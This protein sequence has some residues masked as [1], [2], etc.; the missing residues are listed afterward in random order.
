[1]E[2]D[3]MR[4]P[5]PNDAQYIAL[6]SG[7]AWLEIGQLP[8]AMTRGIWERE[9][10]ALCALPA[11]NPHPSGSK[12]NISLRSELRRARD[13]SV[14]IFPPVSTVNVS[15]LVKKCLVEHNLKSKPASAAAAEGEDCCSEKSSEAERKMEQRLQ[16]SKGMGPS[17]SLAS[18][19]PILP[20]ST[21]RTDR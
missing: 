18:P 5:P 6:L 2:E 12:K 14:L 3:N 16:I 8:D 21:G 7:D 1:M 11:Q 4:R 13:V 15:V 9:R 19:L 20:M 17:P 10:D